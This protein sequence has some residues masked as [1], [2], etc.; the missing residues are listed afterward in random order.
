MYT[1]FG[2]RNFFEYGVLVDVKSYTE[3]KILY[4]R[5]FDGEEDLFLFADCEVDITDSWIDKGAIIDYTGLDEESIDIAQFAI[6]CV[7]YYGVENF[8]SPYNGYK[9]TRE[10]IKEQLKY[11]SISSADLDVT[12]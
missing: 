6:G 1:N 8:S 11:Y 2:D 3:I 10:E 7:E 12:W 5:P 4:C 9:F